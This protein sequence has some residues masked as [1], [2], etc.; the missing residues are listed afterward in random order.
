MANASDN[1]ERFRTIYFD[2]CAERLDDLRDKLAEMEEGDAVE[3]GLHAIFRNVHSIKA[4]AGAFR[5]ERLVA[6]AHIFENILDL[7]RDGSIPFTKDIS[8][9]LIQ[10]SDVLTDLVAS[11]Q[12]GT[13][14]PDG[15]E[16]PMLKS[17]QACVP[18]ADQ[19]A[20]AGQR[21]GPDSE[22]ATPAGP[23]NYEIVFKPHQTL[24]HHANEPLFMIREL[25]RLGTLTVMAD[26]S[27]IPSFDRFDPELCYL[28]WTFKLT[29]DAKPS[30]IEDVFEFVVDDS[31]ISIKVLDQDTSNPSQDKG[32]GEDAAESAATTDPSTGGAGEVSASPKQMRVSSIRVDL[33]RVDRLVNMVGELVIAQSMV[34]Q[35]IR[36]ESALMDVSQLTEID[37]LTQRTRELQEG[38][39]AIRMQPVKSAFMRMP[40]LVRDLAPRLGKKA[41]LET[42][43]EATE[44]D[45]TVIEELSE[46]LTHM[47]RNALDHGLEQ[48]DER[49]ASGKEEEGIIN[50]TAEHRSGR[51]VISVSDDG[52][53]LNAEKIRKRAVERGILAEG[54]PL[55]QHEMK[56]LIFAPGFSTAAEI[57]DVSGRGVGMDVVKRK[58]QDLGG[59]ISVESEEGK[60]TTFIMTLPL[61]LAVLDGM[62]VMVGSEQYVVPLASIIETLHPT[63]SDMRRLADG[64][65]V[66][67]IRE[68]F[69]PIIHL[70]KTF[71][72]EDDESKDLSGLVILVE[73]ESGQR[74]ALAVDELLGQ[75]QVV[76]KNLEENYA[77]IDGVAGA[78]ILGNGKVALIIDVDGLV[79]FG[80]RAAST[81]TQVLTCDQTDLPGTDGEGSIAA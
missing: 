27:D 64:V 6:F 60:G 44:V 4:G 14:L 61:T 17:L 33:D 66:L 71:G 39:M 28:K 19:P 36:E 76:I 67:L 75:Q 59:R 3:E 1:Y 7:L 52:R 26:L 58:V 20:A 56:Q 9:I 80:T 11:A 49:L 43:G 73:T 42:A 30:D 38:V 79:E 50:L 77:A 70:K 5:F 45:K 62:M 25:G 34:L 16:E 65:E 13:H 32:A 53:G 47:I 55:S 69:V 12:S 57:S 24:F 18:G 37:D 29:S 54:A 15:Y 63:R 46:P 41:R 78:T 81:D 23:A 8:S 31:D 21:D 35:R 68:R 51:I 72:I 48:P 2:E 74:V 22:D 10:S 40:R